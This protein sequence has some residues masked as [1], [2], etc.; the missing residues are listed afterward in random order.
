MTEVTIVGTVLRATLSG[1]PV[2]GQT[3]VS[4]NGEWHEAVSWPYRSMGVLTTE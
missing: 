4:A 2:G 1:L 3:V